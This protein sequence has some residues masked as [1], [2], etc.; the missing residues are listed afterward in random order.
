MGLLVVTHQFFRAISLNS[1]RQH[2]QEWPQGL[3]YRC[4]T[5]HGLWVSQFTIRIGSQS[6]ASACATSFVFSFLVLFSSIY[7]VQ[8]CH[9]LDKAPRRSNDIWILQCCLP[10]IHPLQK[11]ICTDYT[12]D[13][14]DSSVMAQRPRETLHN[15]ICFECERIKG[16]ASYC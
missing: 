2:G 4:T 7:L 1:T 6:A 14:H 12:P 9:S 16:L 5:P 3:R 8:C 11:L 15:E 13:I 10:L